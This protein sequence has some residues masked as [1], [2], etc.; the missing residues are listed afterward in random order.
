MTVARDD[1]R[2]NRLGF[3]PHGFGDMLF[4]TRIDVGEGADRAGNGAGGDFF[5]CRDQARL[6]AI[7]FGIGFGHLEAEGDRLG[8]N[9]VGTTDTD[10][11]L[12]LHGAALEG[13]QQAIHVSQQ[14]IGSAGQLHIE[15]G[16]QHVR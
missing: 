6:A 7:K 1:L 10:R 5:P 15:A 12:M 9:A 14:Q 8:M 11:V 4:N 3:E 16:V 2:G 13:C